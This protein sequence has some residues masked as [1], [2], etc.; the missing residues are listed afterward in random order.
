MEGDSSIRIPGFLIEPEG[1]WRE[2]GKRDRMAMF[3][4]VLGISVVECTIVYKISDMEQLQGELQTKEQRKL[5]LNLGLYLCH[6]QAETH[7]YAAISLICLQSTYEHKISTSLPSNSYRKCENAK[8]IHAVKETP[9][10]HT[11]MY[12]VCSSQ[13]SQS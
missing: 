13:L 11:H 12:S 4:N 6:I 9:T 2:R 10:L 8:A 7:R 1:G 5:G 3:N